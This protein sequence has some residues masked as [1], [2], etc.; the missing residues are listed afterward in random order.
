MLP[1]ISPW[2]F[3][4][5]SRGTYN[6]GT[7]RLVPSAWLSHRIFDCRPLVGELL[8]SVARVREYVHACSMHFLYIFFVIILEDFLQ[9]LV[10]KFQFNM[11]SC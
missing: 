1:P 11:D 2:K 4:L 6:R 7:L 9:T 5:G 10:T 8:R 3:H